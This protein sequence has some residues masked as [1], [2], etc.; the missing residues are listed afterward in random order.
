[1][2]DLWNIYSTELML[3]GASI[4]QPVLDTLLIKQVHVPIQAPDTW[5]LFSQSIL[6]KFDIFGFRVDGNFTGMFTNYDLVPEFSDNFFKNEVF[7]VEEESNTKDLVYWDS[8]RPIP[9]TIEEAADYVKKDSLQEIWESRAYLDS[10]DRKRNKFKVWDLLFGYSYANSYRKRYFSLGTPL[11]RLQFNTVQGYYGDFRLRYRQEFDDY[12]M[13]WFELAPKVQYGLGD[14]EWRFSGRMRMQFNR[15]RFTRIG[16]SGGRAAVQF[17]ENEPITPTLNSLYSLLGRRNYLK[18]YDKY[19]VRLD[20]RHE[21]FNGLLL[22]VRTEYA[23]RRNLVN[24]SNNS[25]VDNDRDYLPN[26]PFD[27]QT[28]ALAFEELD[29][30]LL[31]VNLRIRFKQKYLTYPGRKIIMGSKYPDLWLRIRTAI[32]FS[33]QM[34]DYTKLAIEVSDQFSFG[35]VG[36]SRLSV[37]GGGFLRN[38]RSTPIDYRHFNGNQLLISNPDRYMRSFFR[39]PYYEYSTDGAFVEA[40]WQHNFQGFILDKIPAIRK[41]AWK[42]VIS[43]SFLY[44]EDQKDYWELSAG[45]D[46]IGFGVFRLFRIDIVN[47]FARGKYQETA[48]VIG[49]RL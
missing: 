1:T 12:N 35:L 17:N 33:N 16:L 41:L 39:L 4:Q 24:Q 5:M 48:L 3:T 43:A 37:Q 26:Y 44:T 27:N 9:L 45:L 2:E 40:H 46:N 18:L 13:R 38:N 32:P 22:N 29:A 15:T 21:I 31:D 11:T 23:Q 19:F 7:K 20:A 47:S 34:V 30:F 6:F 10:M 42:T 36:Y 14:E 28:D 49:L 25:W 8:I